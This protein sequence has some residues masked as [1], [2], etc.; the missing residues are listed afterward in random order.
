MGAL[1]DL[2]PGGDALHARH[3]PPG[4]VV[5]LGRPRRPPRPAR[6]PR[7]EDQGDRAARRWS[8]RARHG[9]GGRARAQ[10]RLGDGLARPPWIRPHG[11]S[12]CAPRVLALGRLRGRAHRGRARAGRAARRPLRGEP[13]R[14]ARLPGRRSLEAR[15]GSR[16]DH[17]GGPSRERRA[18]R[19]RPRRASRQR[20]PLAP[21]EPAGRDRRVAD[22]DALHVP[23][24]PHLEQA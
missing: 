14:A 11:R 4:G 2:L 22:A 10:A 18:T 16:R 3:Y 13:G 20:G 9:A 19:L 23:H 7:V 24:E 21:R 1:P 15:G 17:A 5:V 8:I 6:G 12:L